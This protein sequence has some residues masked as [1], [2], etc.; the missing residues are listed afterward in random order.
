[1]AALTESLKL[2][3]NRAQASSALVAERIEAIQAQADRTLSEI[4]WDE[5]GQELASLFATADE[6][7]D[8][9]QD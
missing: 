5:R 8:R 4:D 9:Y 1:M 2:G 7:G 3:V 6:I